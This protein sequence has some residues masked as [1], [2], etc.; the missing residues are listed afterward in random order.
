[1]GNMETIY[2]EITCK[3]KDAEYVISIPSHTHSLWKLGLRDYQVFL[4]LVI[5][6]AWDPNSYSK[7]IHNILELQRLPKF[8][9]V[10]A[11]KGRKV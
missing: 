3:E 9:E 1:M 11:C 5:S 6:E 2:Q 4:D 8:Y 7:T 10:P